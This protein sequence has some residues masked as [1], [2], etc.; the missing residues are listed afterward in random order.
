MKTIGLMIA[1]KDSNRLK[2]KNFKDFCGKPMFV[3]NLEKMLKIFDKVYV[4][5][6]HNFIL[7]KAEEM[8]AIAIKRPAELCG[9]VPNIPVYRHILENVENVEIIV[10]VQANSPTIKE[11]LI[12][13][14][15]DIM[16]KHDFEELLTC[17]YDF[18]PYG[19]IWAMTT[20]RLKN[21]DN[22]YKQIPQILLVDD[23]IDIHTEED[24]GKAK[25]QYLS[26]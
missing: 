13:K 3:W 4:S 21:Y 5:S 15:K 14:A 1:K 12:K 24:L 6:D 20:K 17:H 22:F 25:N 8:G 10:A 16:E 7:K 26:I 19:S 23:S 2:D 9:E 11:S 18:K